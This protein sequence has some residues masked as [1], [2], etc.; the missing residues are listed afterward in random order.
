MKCDIIIP[1]WNKLELTRECLDSIIK[2]THIPYRLIIIDNN[3]DQETENYLKSL[4]DRDEI[5]V[6]L[7]R[8]EQNLGFVKAVNQGIRASNAEYVCLLNNDTLVM[9][10]WLREMINII[11]NNPKV[12][13]VNPGGEIAYSNIQGLSGKWVE[14]GFA[15]GFC[16]LIKRE[17]IEKIGLLD[18]EFETGFFED[19]DYC[20]RAKNAG[21]LCVAAKASCVFHHA[22]KTF[23]TW[24]KDRVNE[25]FEKNRE[26]FTQR[27]GEILQIAYIVFNRDIKES[28][29]AQILK[30]SRDG[31]MVYFFLKS[32]VKLSPD[33]SHGSLRKYVCP[34]IL[35]NIYV[36]GKV[37]I[38]NMR[39]KRFNIVFTDSKIFASILKLC[40]PKL[41]IEVI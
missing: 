10:N 24:Q 1:V 7:I 30:L 2:N 35:F 14:V 21:Y 15:S 23:E 19:T 41:K 11:K 29:I 33:V 3:S 25:L 5:E 37:V 9:E 34:D 18:E 4:K 13:V 12:G 20:K 31:H 26:V 22:H 36:F 6:V 28:S 16:M 27:W 17:V 32:S 38:R 8:N 40:I 39:K